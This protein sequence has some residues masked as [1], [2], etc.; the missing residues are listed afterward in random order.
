MTNNYSIRNPLTCQRP[1]LTWVSTYIHF[2]VAIKYRR[3]Y[4]NTSA[5]VFNIYATLL[6]WTVI[7]DSSLTKRTSSKCNVLCI[8]T[9]PDATFTIVC[10][11]GVSE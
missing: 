6:G 2:A 3:Q 9:N 4:C 11:S 1:I 7:W 5:C 8:T 10:K